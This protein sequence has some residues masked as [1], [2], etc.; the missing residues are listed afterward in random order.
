MIKVIVCGGRDFK[1]YALL[2]EKLDFFLQSY[3]KVEIVSGMAKGADSLALR[4]AAANNFP[5]RKFPAD[6]DTHGRSAGYKRNVQMSEYATHCVAFWNGT[7]KG[8]SHM[9]DL[10]KLMNLKLRVV[11]Y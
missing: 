4:Y 7:S 10:S 2:I 5:T 9:I 11:K 3:E 6:W 8:T 1:D